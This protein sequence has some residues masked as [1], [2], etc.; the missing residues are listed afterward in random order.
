MSEPDD[1]RLDSVGVGPHAGPWPVDP[2]F[3]PELLAT[4]DRRNVV[5]RYRYWTMDAIVA[6]LDSR[7]H[8]FDVAIENWQHDLNI[9]TRAELEKQKAN[10]SLLQARSEDAKLYSPMR[11]VILWASPDLVDTLQ[12]R[13]VRWY[14]GSKT[15]EA[16][17]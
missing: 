4:G 17:N 5:D 12:L 9:G 7:R 3:D 10:V 14:Y 15:Q 11:G 13:N 8:P 1:P 16:W 2:R 6:D